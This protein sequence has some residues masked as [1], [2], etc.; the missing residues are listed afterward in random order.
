MFELVATGSQKPLTQTGMWKRPHTVLASIIHT[1]FLLLFSVFILFAATAVQAATESSATA[2]SSAQLADL[3]EN[4]QTRKQLIEQLRAQIPDTQITTAAQSEGVDFDDSFPGKV[5]QGTQAFLTKVLDDFGQAASTVGAMVQGEELGGIQMAHWKSAL[6]NLLL[7]IAVTVI[8]FVLSRL[9]AARF[10]AR[11]NHWV[12]QSPQFTKPSHHQ[13]LSVVLRKAAAVLAALVIDVLA[14]VLAG[15]AGYGMVLALAGT[16]GVAGVFES[17]FVNAFVVVELVRAL[18]RTVFATRFPQ[19]RLFVMSDELAR[20]WNAWL[21]KLVEVV[22]Y[23]ML[24]IVPV[25]TSLFTPA[26]GS[27]VGLMIMLGV[28]IYAV[29]GIWHNRVQIRERLKQRANQ[30]LMPFLGTLMRLFA[31]IWHILAIIYFTV[32][33]VVSQ[34]DPDNALPFMAQATLQTVL[35]IVLGLLVSV[36]LTAILSRRIRLSDDMRGR[37]PLLEERI[38]SYVPATLKGLR[39]FTIGV[40]LLVVLD[41]WHAF[42]LT[43]WVMS[44]SGRSTINMVVHVAII[45][46]LATLSWTV[47]ASIIE[48]R[49]SGTGHSAPSAREKTLL[50]L[51]RNAALIVIITMTALVV[52][53]QIGINI[54]PL[55]AGAGVVGLAIGFGAQKL[56]Q[57]IITGVFIQLENGMNVNDVVEAGGV[58]GTVEKM[59]I[60]SVGMRTLDGGYHLIPF[61]SVDVVVNHMRDFSY[62]MGEYTIAHRENVD[63]AIYHLQQAFNELM[64]DEVLA[65]EIL[66]EI[67]IPGVTA[68]NE[69]GVTIRVLIKTTP[70]MQWAVQ[71]GYNRLVKKHFNAA[72][73]ELPYPHTVVYFGQ[74]RNGHAPAANVHLARARPRSAPEGKAA[75]AGHTPGRLTP[76]KPGSADV[77]GNELEQVVPD[78][79]DEE[80]ASSGNPNP[81]S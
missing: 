21:S 28:Y 11:I 36:V 18:V 35:A 45:L 75:A 46:L 58:F 44:E 54:G 51:F 68:I 27:M 42:D 60:R 76:V 77:L 47:I 59:T 15:L 53:S 37:L 17:L 57:D 70:G 66:E 63:D 79:G 8:A 74:D 6:L 80:Q 71:R 65:P 49:L 25:F 38:N 67:T 4:E 20:Y 10:F 56:V 39:L 32:L 12:A 41:A 33:L 55:I 34:I 13:H 72:N 22:G 14:I 62:H 3:L 30:A 78:E 1:F 48:S 64:Q 73:I 19:L 26:F 9:L 43:G 50:S 5:A 7:V 29:R 23:G 52:L 81:A 16:D 31:R 2:A 24:V 61:S 40:I 69:K